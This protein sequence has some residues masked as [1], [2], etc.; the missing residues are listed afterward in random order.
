MSDVRFIVKP[1]V[2]ATNAPGLSQL[3]GLIDFF[4]NR[5]T[6]HL[7]QKKGS[8]LLS[9]RPCQFKD[10]FLSL[11]NRLGH[12]IDNNVWREGALQAQKPDLLDDQGPDPQLYRILQ[13]FV[14]HRHINLLPKRNIFSKGEMVRVVTGG[15]T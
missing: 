13:F 6:N 11:P 7:L 8:F 2:Q 4:V 3:N 1:A 5:L 10:F 15:E 12:P 9:H 14:S